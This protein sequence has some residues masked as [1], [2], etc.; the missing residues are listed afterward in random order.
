M[1]KNDLRKQFKERR[2]ALTALE[3][4]EQSKAIAQRF[5]GFFDV[6]QMA[7]IHSYLPIESQHEVN[8]FPILD[9]IHNRFPDTQIVVPRVIP[10]TSDLE[11]YVWKPDIQL[12][13]NQ[14]NIPEP[15]NSYQLSF[16]GYQL[17][18]IPLLGYDTIGN[19]V[20]YGKGYYDRFLSQCLPDTIKVGL[21]FF[22]PVELIDDLNPHDI[23]LDYCVSPTKVW[24][25]D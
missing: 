1:T 15:V 16:I 11:H 24:E 2:R 23:R 20:G 22:E 25:F 21:S 7:A 18:I 19:R 9:V 12:T 4:A 3:V 17:I 8:T 13:Q 5:V 14:W 10:N 6:G